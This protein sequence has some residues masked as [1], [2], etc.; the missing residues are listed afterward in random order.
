MKLSYPNHLQNS[1]T[2]EPQT[3]KRYLMLQPEELQQLLLDLNLAI[4]LI[5]YLKPSW[6]HLAPVLKRY[7]DLSN[8]LELNGIPF[9]ELNILESTNQLTAKMLLPGTNSFLGFAG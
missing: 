8:K 2:N 7:R 9:I 6:P 1:K 3:S 4:R 5:M